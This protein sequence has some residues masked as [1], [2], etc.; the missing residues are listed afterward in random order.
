[1]LQKDT[2]VKGRGGKATK[3]IKNN[4]VPYTLDIAINTSWTKFLDHVSQVL[5]LPSIHQ[6]W[7]ESFWWFFNKQDVKLPLCDQDGFD[8]L[9][10]RFCAHK[11]NQSK[12]VYLQM[13]PPLQIM[14]ISQDCR[15]GLSASYTTF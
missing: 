4:P 8:R 2:L 7:Q 9:L 12:E 10:Q 6:L 15:V 13:Q 11:G 5:H 3:A 14:K 1:M